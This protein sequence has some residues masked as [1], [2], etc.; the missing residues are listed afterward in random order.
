MSSTRRTDTPARY[1]FHEG[2]QV[3]PTDPLLLSQVESFIQAAAS[4]WNDPAGLISSAMRPIL[5]GE[6][7][8]Q[9]TY[10]GPSSITVN[11]KIEI[12]LLRPVRL[13]SPRIRQRERRFPLIANRCDLEALPNSGSAV[14]ELQR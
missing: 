10:T 12:G 1:I 3:K 7:M 5:K 4:V 13:H 14:D 8:A 11:A 9:C 6:L 2:G